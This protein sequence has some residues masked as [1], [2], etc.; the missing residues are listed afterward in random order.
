MKLYKKRRIKFCETVKIDKWFVKVYTIF[1][2]ES[3]QSPG[4]YDLAISSLS[5]WL[6]MGNSFNSESSNIAFLILHEGK[7]GI[8]AIIN[9]WVGE[10]MLNTHIF[11]TEY[12]RSDYRIISG[13]GLAPCI[14]ELEVINHERLAWIEHVLKQAEQ[15]DYTSY[16]KEV[17]NGEL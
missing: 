14:W 5:R 1:Q 7:E 10:N 11:F 17:Y 3:F 16:M 12:E 8:F 15:P 6:A 13:D 4:D 2:F 9:W